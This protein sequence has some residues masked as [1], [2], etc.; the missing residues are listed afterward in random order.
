MLHV[1]LVETPDNPW[2]QQITPSCRIMAQESFQKYQASRKQ[3]QP[4]EA[5]PTQATQYSMP[6]VSSLQ[7]QLGRCAHTHAQQHMSNSSRQTP[8]RC[9]RLSC[10]HSHSL[11]PDY[12]SA[13]V[14][15]TSPHTLR[16]F[17]VFSTHC[18]DSNTANATQVTMHNQTHNGART[19]FLQWLA[20]TVGYHTPTKPRQPP[21]TPLPSHTP[22][23]DTP[24]PS[25]MVCTHCQPAPDCSNTKAGAPQA[26]GASADIFVVQETQFNKLG[27][28]KQYLK[29]LHLGLCVLCHKHTKRAVAALHQQAH[30]RWPSI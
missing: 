25:H 13:D 5:A 3:K 29:A 24:W 17:R 18:C 14:N 12:P 15:Q 1:G 11:P 8:S 19:D 27:S 6:Q 16:V 9:G 23:L 21:W 26:P 7:R 2:E 10:M 30:A 4:R 20:S 22:L 28:S